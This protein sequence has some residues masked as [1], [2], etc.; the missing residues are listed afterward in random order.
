MKKVLTILTAAILLVS[1]MQVSLDRHYCGGN[2]I[3][4]KI[5]VTGKL[6]S[7]GMEQ[8]ESSCP[9]HQAIDKKCCED[10]L[11]FYSL[12]S[13]YFPEYFK[14]SNPTSQRDLLPIHIGNFLPGNSLNTDPVDWV[15]PP[16]DYHKSSL[17]RSEICVFRI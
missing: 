1:G 12:N 9:G 11:S 3:D 14:L 10:Q 5:S 4:V 2:L 6:A 13:N 8:Y 15:L 16:G 7:C 17:K